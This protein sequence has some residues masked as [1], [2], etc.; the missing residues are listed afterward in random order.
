M[1]KN[2][3]RQSFDV[4]LVDQPDSLNN[5]HVPQFTTRELKVMSLIH[6]LSIKDLITFS[7]L[8]HM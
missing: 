1:T 4:S 7:C 6:A 5:I 3:I 2:I 8:D